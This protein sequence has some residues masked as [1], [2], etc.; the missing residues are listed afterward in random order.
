MPS[1]VRRDCRHLVSKTL[2][3]LARPVDRCLPGPSTLKARR[4]YP[5][6]VTTLPV[7]RGHGQPAAPLDLA[8]LGFVGLVPLGP[9]PETR[10]SSQHSADLLEFIILILPA[11]PLLGTEEGMEKLRGN[12]VTLKKTW[13]S[14]NNRTNLTL[15]GNGGRDN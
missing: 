13:F 7:V 14:K 4:A 12:R 6:T 2:A 1:G 9:G 3:L 15:F 11:S 5:S 10:H 8:P